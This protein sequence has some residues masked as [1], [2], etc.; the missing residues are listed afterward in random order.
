[1]CM[2]MC[3]SLPNNACSEQAMSRRPGN[4]LM[5]WMVGWMNGWMHGWLDG[6]SDAWM[7]IERRTD[8]WTNGWMYTLY[9]WMDA[10]LHLTHDIYTYTQLYMCTV[11][12]HMHLLMGTSGKGGRAPR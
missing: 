11:C 7:Q 10:C 6:L 2:H 12:M 4:V 9:G 8:G 3:C 5:G 1:M